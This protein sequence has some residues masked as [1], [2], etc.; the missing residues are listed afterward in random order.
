[1]SEHARLHLLPADTWV[2]ARAGE[3]VLRAVEDAGFEI[4]TLCGG[5][6]IC[7]RCQVVAPAIEGPPK[8]QEREA[9]SQEQL[10][11]GYRLP[12][13]WRIHHDLEVEIVVLEDFSHK[14]FSAMA[15]WPAIELAPSVRRLGVR[16][17][18]PSLEDQRSDSRRPREALPGGEGLRLAYEVAL[19]LPGTLRASSWHVSVTVADDTI[20]EIERHHLRPPIGVAIDIGTTSVAA[21]LVN[22][23]TGTAVDI[24][25]RSSPQGRYGAEVMS[26]IEHA[27]TPGGLQDLQAAVVGDLNR[28]LD[29][30]CARTGVNSE[31][32]AA[33][34]VVGSTTMLHLFLGLSPEHI[35]V[36]P[37]VGVTNENLT[38]EAGRLGLH[39]HPRAE[40]YVLPSVAGFVGTH[41]VGGMP[42]TRMDQA[43]GTRL[44]MDIGTNGEIALARDGEPCTASAPAGP[45]FE[46]GEIRHGMRAATGAIDEVAVGDDGAL[47]FSTIGGERP[48]GLCASAL[49]DLCAELFRV[50]LVDGSGRLLGEEEVRARGD[51][52]A[53]ALARRVRTV[54]GVRELVVGQAGE[55]AT[56]KPIVLTQPDVRQYRLA[57]GAIKAGAATLLADLGLGAD[58]LEGVFLAGSFGSH[59]GVASALRTG[60]VPDVEV[61][62]IHDVGNAALEGARMALL[63]DRHRAAAAALALR[64]HHVEPSGRPDF[65]ER[66]IASLAFGP[67]AVSH[68]GRRRTRPRAQR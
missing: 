1:M 58:A 14:A 27:A 17:G 52:R 65:N 16:L 29:E 32:I 44:L 11:A 46:G 49:V 53:R 67:P 28:I 2:E 18:P 57:K 59:I 23:R 31:D 6:E 30:S 61:E 45:A 43:D 47:V 51:A 5:R 8:H 66:F 20:V 19:R 33:L 7:H 55:S 35:G 15:D 10:A 64:A 38:L 36:T 9:F 60:L 4:E 3:T 22:L 13:L 68:R 21:L 42:A 56:G 24:G 12:C 41:T 39:A 40:L 63:D 62:R 25:A 34:T 54:D 50:G 26:R 37:F 48:R